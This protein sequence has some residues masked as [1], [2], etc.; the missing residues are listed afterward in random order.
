MKKKSVLLASLLFAYSTFACAQESTISKEEKIYKSINGSGLKVLI[1]SSPEIAQ[2][3]NN[4]A[5]AF[6]HGGGWVFGSPEEFTGACEWYARKGFIAFSFQYRLSMQAD[7]TYPDPDITPVESVKDARSALRWLRENAESLRIGPDK[8]VAGGQSAGGQ[9][10]LSTALMENI[11][12]NTDNLAISPVPDALVLYSSSVNTMEAWIDWILGA[13]RDQ[14][15]AIS[16]HHNLKKNMP[17]AIGFHG[18]DDCTV[19]IY[20]VRLFQDRMLELGNQYELIIYPGRKHYL[21]EGNATYSR[22]F[23]EEILE[24]TDTFLTGLGYLEKN[25]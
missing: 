3:Q 18:E 10:A 19:P 2:N 8:I 16:P 17:P 22:L 4:P 12:E 11:N 15:W 24:R 5:I 13:R 9:L 23:D 1:F 14:I 7:G 6:F 20:V 21:G 25:E